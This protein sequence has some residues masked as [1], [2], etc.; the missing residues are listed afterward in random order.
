MRMKGR[1]P[2]ILAVLTVAVASTIA[3]PARAASVN[4]GPVV[5]TGQVEDSE[6][7][8]A[9]G[10][11]VVLLAQPAVT[12]TARIGD[13][14][15]VLP[16]DEVVTDSTG[17]F[18][19]RL[20]WTEELEQ[21]VDSSSG[22]LDLEVLAT[23]GREMGIYRFTVA[24][25]GVRPGVLRDGDVT[26]ARD[27]A[28]SRDSGVKITL[29]DNGVASK[30]I[31]SD[32][33]R[34]KSQPMP[35]QYGCVITNVATYTPFT[36]IGTLYSTWS[37]FSGSYQYQ[38]SASST[39]GVGYSTTGVL[40]SYSMSGTSTKA[41]SQLFTWYPSGAFKK[42]FKVQWK[43]FKQQS[44]CVFEFFE[45]Y[46]YEV[47]PQ[48]ATGGGTDA[49]AASIPATPAANCVQQN[50]FTYST[51]NQT[52]INWTNGVTIGSLIGIDLS[53]QSN[54]TTSHKIAISTTAQRKVCGTNGQPGDS[55]FGELVVKPPAGS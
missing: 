44:H 50:G 5:V 28:R 54:W 53:A 24:L 30:S 49:T 48:N 10:G 55:Y 25:S 27:P 39:L 45:Y 4:D 20:Q 29:S 6:S 40:G 37:S 17:K 22:Y 32:D 2:A 47:V 51:T 43:Y 31:A 9:A 36:L 52:A 41:S 11:H 15:K 33:G 1:A 19:L 26:L 23:V 21:Y 16:L 46:F 13:S 12:P 7:A 14:Q 18:S 35:K 34:S 8:P 3:T 38:T 42:L